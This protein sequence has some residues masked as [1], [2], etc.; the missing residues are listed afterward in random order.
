MIWIVL[1]VFFSCKKKETKFTGQKKGSTREQVCQNQNCWDHLKLTSPCILNNERLKLLDAND[2]EDG[3]FYQ[4]YPL[5]KDSQSKSDDFDEIYQAT[6]M[7]IVSP[8]KRYSAIPD[9]KEKYF[10]EKRPLYRNES[11]DILLKALKCLR[12]FHYPTL[13]E[14]SDQKKAY[15]INPTYSDVSDQDPFLAQIAFATE[16]KLIKGFGN[17]KFHPGN[18][19]G[20][21]NKHTL[22]TYGQ[23]CRM[24]YEG[25]VHLQ[26]LNPDRSFELMSLPSCQTAKSASVQE[27]GDGIT[28]PL[29]LKCFE[30]YSKQRGISLCQQHQTSNVDVKASIR[31]ALAVS[32]VVLMREEIQ[33]DLSENTLP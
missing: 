17:G 3:G 24:I 6:E 20:A 18:T 26:E 9:L 16:K 2:P 28:F 15:Q 30:D 7:G 29:T 10:N 13:K 4:D 5:S 8:E 27:D 33:K 19:E 32:L 21:F 14:L 23:W 11:V 12:S 22:L 1:I 25:F 31:K